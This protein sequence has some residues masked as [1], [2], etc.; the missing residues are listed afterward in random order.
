MTDEYGSLNNPS[1]DGKP[2]F[3]SKSLDD[4]QESVENDQNISISS[5]T[6]E[7]E[8]LQSLRK[9]FY[10]VRK[11][12]K[13]LLREYA[14]MREAEEVNISLDEYR[15]L[16]N[17][18]LRNPTLLSQVW[19]W[20]G[21]SE[22]KLWDY[23][24]LLIVPIFLAFGAYYLNQL[25]VIRADKASE[26]LSKSDRLIANSR[27]Q[28]ETLSNYLTEMTQ[29]LLDKHLRGAD[30]NN[31]VWSLARART[32]IVLWKLDGP[33]KGQVL[34][35]LKEAE[36]IS[37]KRGGVIRL[38]GVNLQDADLRN[39]DLRDSDLKDADLRGA[40]LQGA[41][42]ENADLRSAH[43]GSSNLSKRSKLSKGSNL[44]KANLRNA[45]LD[46]ANLENA[47]LRNA[48]MKNAILTNTI[49]CHTI[50]PNGTESNQNC[51]K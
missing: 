47:N 40:Q 10:K 49:Q 2:S 46:S 50:M 22:K 37:L 5:N 17:L 35:F 42:L 45:N 15:R 9:S 23:L 13:G 25:S 26:A 4:L 34:Q 44:S 39:A 16:Y 30:K 41:N 48:D 21:F 8:R 7:G 6:A 14:L 27:Y 18:S 33:Y 32:I 1:L 29:L 3:N 51:V 28:Q 43:L 38:M 12:P 31:E 20:T 19:K 24:Q 11:E 36:L